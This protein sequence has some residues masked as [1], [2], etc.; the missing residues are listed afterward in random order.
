MVPPF[1]RLLAES[2]TLRLPPNNAF[3][4]ALL[5][6]RERA[7]SALGYCAPAARIMRHR[8]AAQLER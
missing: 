4:R 1:L 7:A 8:A 3:E 6:G 2:T 5:R